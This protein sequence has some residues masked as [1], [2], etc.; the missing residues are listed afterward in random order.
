MS[1]VKL[2]KKWSE[3]VYVKKSC[4][5]LKK[6]QFSLSVFKIGLNWYCEIMQFSGIFGIEA[7]EWN[8]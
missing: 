4:H 6:L 8:M 3:C 1:T 7:T 5:Y 2:Q